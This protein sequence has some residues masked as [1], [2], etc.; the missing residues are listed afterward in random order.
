MYWLLVTGHWFLASGNS[1]VEGDSLKFAV[2][3]STVHIL[4]KIANPSANVIY[5]YITD[6][7]GQ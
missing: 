5:L 4:Y 2:S 1:Q 7:R 3:R 6:A